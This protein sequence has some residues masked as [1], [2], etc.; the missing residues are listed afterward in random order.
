MTL[1][2]HR[3]RTHPV[4]QCLCLGAATAVRFRQ[5]TPL[6]FGCPSID[7]QPNGKPH[8]Y[9]ASQHHDLRKEDVTQLLSLFFMV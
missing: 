3:Q 6:P 9:H 2:L 1:R 5:H 4:S 7:A 8:H